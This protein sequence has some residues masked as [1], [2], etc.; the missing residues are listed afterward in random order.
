MRVFCGLR[1]LHR[2]GPLPAREKKDKS[3]CERE[4]VLGR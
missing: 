1:A 4:C 3:E 2:L